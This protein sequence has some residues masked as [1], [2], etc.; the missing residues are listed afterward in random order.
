MLAAYRTWHA[1]GPGTAGMRNEKC[2][3]SCSGRLPGARGGICRVVESASRCGDDADLIDYG[4]V[5]EDSAVHTVVN[6]VGIG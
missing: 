3:C 2:S 1:G 4:H 5:H 6:K